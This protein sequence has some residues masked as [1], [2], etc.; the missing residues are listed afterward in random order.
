VGFTFPLYY[1]VAG[2]PIPPLALS[3][4]KSWDS[5]WLCKFVQSENVQICMVLTSNSYD[6][7]RGI[8]ICIIYPRCT[9]LYN[10]K[11]QICMILTEAYK[12]VHV[13]GDN[14]CFAHIWT[15]G[16]LHLEVFVIMYAIGRWY[17]H[18]VSKW[19]LWLTLKDTKNVRSK[20]QEKIHQAEACY[21]EMFDLADWFQQA[22]SH[23]PRK[24]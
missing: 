2:P 1:G 22:T 5:S 18:C 10:L 12:F 23:H 16:L 8:Q 4:A 3:E 11:L 24:R 15:T 19:G 14:A 17:W 9:D 7:D 13:W 20:K 21:S 6:I